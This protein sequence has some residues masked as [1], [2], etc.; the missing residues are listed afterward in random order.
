MAAD[1][2]S[3]RLPFKRGMRGRADRG[4]QNG[5]E[6]RKRA[7][8]GSSSQEVV[9]VWRCRGMEVWARDPMRSRM[10]IGGLPRACASVWKG[11][12]WHQWHQWHGLMQRR[13]AGKPLPSLAGNDKLFLVD[14]GAAAECT[15][16]SPP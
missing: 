10:L 15:V 3:L 13:R 7:A 11:A 2:I 6:Q 1:L 9:E 5:K 14:R 4:A 16:Q 8:Q 12:V